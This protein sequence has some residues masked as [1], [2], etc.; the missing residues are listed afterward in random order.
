[1]S[2]KTWY[3]VK[4]DLVTD[5][6]RLYLAFMERTEED[7][8][9]Q[10]V[11]P[12][13]HLRKIPG[14]QARVPRSYALTG[15]KPEFLTQSLEV[16]L[17]VEEGLS[18]SLSLSLSHAHTHTHTHICTHPTN[19]LPPRQTLE[20]SQTKTYIQPTGPGSHHRLLHT[21]SLSHSPRTDQKRMLNQLQILGRANSKAK[22]GITVFH[23]Q[24]FVY[25]KCASLQ[26]AP[27]PCFPHPLL[28][29]GKAAACFEGD[30]VPRRA[31]GGM[32]RS[33]DF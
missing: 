12:Q 1:M 14:I 28:S 17:T 20:H 23:E 5:V 21:T 9:P 24:V 29:L 32:S 2:K 16:E 33:A 25:F 6:A 11:S 10:P 3:S 4:R 8:P 19:G 13:K 31:P 26:N 30:S 18:L 15:S 22:S 7:E 27:S